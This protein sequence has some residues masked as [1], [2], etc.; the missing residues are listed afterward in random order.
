MSALASKAF[1][2]FARFVLVGGCFV[3]FRMKVANTEL[4]PASGAY[5]V[6]P[7]HRSILDTFIAASVTRR[8]VRFMG[9]QELWANRAISWLLTTLGGFPVDRGA[10]SGAVKAALSVI[11]GGEP[12][13][14]FP[15]GTRRHGD[16]IEDLQQGAAY[17]AVKRGVP[18]VPVGIAGTEEILA[19]GKAIPRLKKVAVVIGAPIH[20]RTTGK[21]V[22]RAEVAR[23]TAELE[24]E[25]QALFDEANR[26]I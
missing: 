1:Y 2:Q 14:V 20:P 16:R 10:G 22:N 6:V 18:L 15:E 5:V 11:D 23:M 8:R 13:V 26:R 25:L 21:T 17:L 4:V 9:K 12:V 3:L 7:T 24:V 19:S